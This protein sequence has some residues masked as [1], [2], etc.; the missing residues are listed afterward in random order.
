MLK[1]GCNIENAK[2]LEPNSVDVAVGHIVQIIASVSSNSFMVEV[3]YTLFRQ[4]FNSI[5][6][7]FKKTFCKRL[8]AY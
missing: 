8:K 7:T 3:Y 6:E 2:M 1:G 4:S 5:L